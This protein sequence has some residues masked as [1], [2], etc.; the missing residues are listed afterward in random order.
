MGATLKSL[1]VISFISCL[2][3]LVTYVTKDLQSTGCLSY[4]NGL[5]VCAVSDM[6]KITKTG[7]IPLEDESFNLTTGPLSL[8]AAKN[9][10][11]SFQLLL[12]SA[13]QTPAP[14]SEVMIEIDDLISSE[15]LK[16]N[17]V[18]NIKLFK[19]QYHWVEQGGYSWGPKSDVLD[20]PDNYPD[21]L[22]PQSMDC[23]INNENKQITIL[24]SFPVPQGKDENQ[25]IW[26]DIYIPKDQAAGEYQ[27]H[28]N[29]QAAETTHRIPV[30]V[31]VWNVSLPD[32]PSIDAVGELYD[33]YVQ[34]GIATDLSD[35]AWRDMAHCYQQM[36][37]K[38]RMVFTER[39]WSKAG[40]SLDAYNEAY[41]AILNG[42]L[43]TESMGYT[44]PG[45]GLPVSVWRTPWP[46]DFN[47]RVK[48]PLEQQQINDYEYQAWKWQKNSRQ[49]GWDQTEY[50][51]YIFDE[52]D[53]ATDED[54]LGDVGQDYIGMVHTQMDRVQKAIDKATGDQSIDLIWT[55]HADAQVWDGIPNEDLKDSIRFWIPTASSAN[56]EYYA[57]RKNA[58]D[59]IWFYH[60][61]HPAVGI[62]SI[63]ASGIEMRSWGVITAR[64]NFD[65]HFMWA[66]NLSN[67][68]EPYRYPSYKNED[69]R[70]GNGTMVY[71][72]N[73][74][75]TIGLQAV[76]GP[77]PSMRLKA[78]RRGL[79]DAELIYLARQAG[80]EVEVNKLLEALIPNALSEG[81][82]KASWSDKP[83]DWIQFRVSLLEL[84]SRP[85]EQCKYQIRKTKKRVLLSTLFLFTKKLYS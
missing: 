36:A 1:F 80:H 84:A 35:P 43:F 74:L 81:K 20:W 37:H 38:H 14:I 63:N 56:T 45:E 47:A 62:H 79:Q 6:A 76:P 60:S 29:I 12:K 53:G 30:T 23:R 83:E 66:L 70:F 33:T 69:D 44:G 24:D 72:G 17:S 77:I 54:D 75:D 25:S 52:V 55:S 7:D 41:D 32:K 48:Q 2:F 4:D 42:Q 21:A 65:G 22:I 67:E 28:I 73:K 26:V 82:D 8:Q 68:E 15:Q 64:Y 85:A 5:Q 57:E 34:E 11:I 10:T 31:K 59:K 19:A 46:Q 78:W 49:N 40:E 61:G 16:V 58:G 50:F 13:E 3:F 39:L 71:A 18:K 9:E 27:T 51:A